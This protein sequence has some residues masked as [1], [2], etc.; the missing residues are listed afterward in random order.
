MTDDLAGH[1]GLI[2]AQTP[3]GVI[4]KDGALPWH[5]PEDLAHFRHVTNGFPVVM[6]RATWQS[7]P[8]R[9]RPL[10]GRVNLVLSRDREFAAAG[11]RV[12][13]SLRAALEAAYD[14]DDE[15]W[16]IG[17]AAVYAAALPLADRL[18]V[19]EVELDVDGDAFAPVVDPTRWLAVPGPWLTSR[20][21]VRYRF[22][23]HTRR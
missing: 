16:V 8:E 22:V 6:G 17:G 3:G 10:P 18:E 7:L 21:G 12:A 19:T 13:P 5:V 23:T 9:F 4:G 15:A 20:T 11:A 1:L 2:W 14:E